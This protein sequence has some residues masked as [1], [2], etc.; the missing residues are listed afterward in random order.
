M[1]LPPR[2]ELYIFVLVPVC[3]GSHREPV[4]DQDFT[5]HNIAKL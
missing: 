3:V 1:K 5:V 2:N 4:Q